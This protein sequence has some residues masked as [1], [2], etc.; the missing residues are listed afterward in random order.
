MTAGDYRA[1]L[2]A[3]I[4]EYE[5]LGAQRRQIDD[6]LAQLAQ[7]IGTLTRLLGLSPTVP[8]GLTDA[9]RL[10]LR[11]SGLPLTPVEVRDRLQSMGVDLSVYTNDLSAI[12]TIL[13]RLNDASEIRSAA[14]A[15]KPAYVW[16]HG[17][18]SASIV[19]NFAQLS[20][21]REGGDPPLTRRPAKRKEG[22]K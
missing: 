21:Q 16:N 4:K 9:C 3:A 18:P 11:G 17:A 14:K 5:A 13:K 8:I 15:G 12:H 2:Q 10:A 1:A 6:R 7:T 19:P 22:R 20:A